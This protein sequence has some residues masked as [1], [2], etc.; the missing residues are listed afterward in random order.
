MTAESSAESLYSR[1]ID[2]ACGSDTTSG[3]TGSGGSTTATSTAGT[4]GSG[5]ASSTA[6]AGTGGDATTSTTTTTSATGSTGTSMAMGACTSA[7]DAAITMSKDFASLTADCGQPSLGAQPAT[8]SCIKRG[9]GLS[10]ACVVCFDDTVG[11]VVK[12]CFN[13]CIADSGSQACTDC[14]A[15]TGDPAFVACSGL[16]AN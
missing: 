7:A 10:D 2:I 4:G 1:G 12:N 11:C 13:Q 16:P 6:T 15:A 14:R 3:T 9:T 5:G 8:K